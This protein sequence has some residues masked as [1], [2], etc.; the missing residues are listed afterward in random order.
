MNRYASLIFALSACVLL[1]ARCTRAEGTDG[2]NTKEDAIVKIVLTKLDVN[3]QKLEL[4]WKITNNTEH[5]VW[6]CDGYMDFERFMDKDAKTLVLRKRFNL[7]EGPGWEHPPRAH[8]VRLRPGQEKLDSIALDVPVT[9]RTVFRALSGNARYAERVAL[10]IGF[11]DEDLRAL[12]LDIVEMA[13][14]LSCDGSVSGFDPNWELYP[15]FFGGVSIAQTFNHESFRYFRNSVTSDGDE[16][17]IPYFSQAINGEQI[18]RIEVDNVSIPYKSDYPPL[19]SQ[20][21]K[22]PKNPQSK[23]PD[24]GAKLAKADGKKPLKQEDSGTGK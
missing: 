10:E 1:L 16:I 11:Y 4:N 19:A 12:I 9:P 15:R 3:D 6:V 23:K 21:G 17:I 18:L 13:E 5:D 7:P 2:W 22:G 14:K 8:Y 20:A 24:S